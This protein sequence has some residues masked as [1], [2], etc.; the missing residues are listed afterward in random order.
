MAVTLVDGLERDVFCFFY[1]KVAAIKNGK[2][3]CCYDSAE[4]HSR[5]INKSTQHLVC[6]KVSRV[7]LRTTPPPHQVKSGRP[8]HEVGVQVVESSTKHAGSITAY[9]SCTSPSGHGPCNHIL[10]HNK[11]AHHSAI[12]SRKV[13]HVLSSS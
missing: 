11:H 8:S 7:I 4:L 2:L 5:K 12:R 13:K 10:Q 9:I 6:S 1:T 3:L